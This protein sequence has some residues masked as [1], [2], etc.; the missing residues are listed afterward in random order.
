MEKPK[1][2]KSCSQTIDPQNSGIIG[3]TQCIVDLLGTKLNKPCSANSYSDE[4]E[5]KA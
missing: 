5:V 3:R 2:Q 1:Q 4:K